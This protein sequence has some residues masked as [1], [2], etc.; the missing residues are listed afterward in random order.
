MSSYRSAHLRFKV[1]CN[2]LPGNSE[3]FRMPL[4]NVT[5]REVLKLGGATAAA[6][7]GALLL[8]GC[9]FGVALYLSSGSFRLRQIDGYRTRGHL[10]PGK[11]VLR[12]LFRKLPRRAR[13]R[14]PKSCVPATGSGEHDEFAGREY[15][16]H[17]IST[18]PRRM[19]HALMT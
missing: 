4:R 16:C 18:L 9:G 5:R 7:L 17:S 10:H 15:C 13:I 1:Y 12:S 11:S 2:S 19:Q 3:R 14:R 6:E 8:H